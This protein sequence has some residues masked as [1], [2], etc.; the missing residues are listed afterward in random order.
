ME[1]ISTYKAASQLQ[2][3]YYEA[4]KF[5]C[6]DACLGV[7]PR[8]KLNKWQSTAVRLTEDCQT[9][10]SLNEKDITL[11]ILAVLMFDVLVP[12]NASNPQRSR[13]IVIPNVG[14]DLTTFRLRQHRQ[15]PVFEHVRPTPERLP[16]STVPMAGPRGHCTTDNLSEMNRC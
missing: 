1:F 16:K 13:E 11:Y 15:L 9:D 2:A 8:N 5:T 7:N 6:P 12:G 10:S 4:A 14:I 3:S